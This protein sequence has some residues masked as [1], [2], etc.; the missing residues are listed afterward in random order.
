MVLTRKNVWVYENIT[1]VHSKLI[2]LW[3]LAKITSLSNHFIR[4]SREIIAI[5]YE[6]MKD[7]LPRISQYWSGLNWF[8][9]DRKG[10]LRLET[11]SF[12]G[13]EIQFCNTVMAELAN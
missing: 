13:L 3:I 5:L 12:V 1:E 8:I 9:S 10:L 2:G 4:M 6:K 7:Q 11:T